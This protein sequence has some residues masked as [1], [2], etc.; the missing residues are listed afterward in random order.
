MSKE[1][2]RCGTCKYWSPTYSTC[3]A[4]VPFWCEVR[5][6]IHGERT[7]IYGETAASDGAECRVYEE[8]ELEKT[9]KTKDK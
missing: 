7:I 9:K 6:N 2:Q 8:S 5:I 3:E 1:R 4:T